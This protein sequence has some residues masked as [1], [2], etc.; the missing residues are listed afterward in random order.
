MATVSKLLAVVMPAIV[1]LF[2]ARPATVVS[3]PTD[4]LQPRFNQVIAQVH[5]AELAGA[6]SDEVAK[7]VVLLNQAVQLN[8]E[9]LKLTRPEVAQRRAQL[10][11]QVDDILNDVQTRANQVE[12]VASQR[13]FT[14][15]VIAYASAG[16]AAF[17]ATL[18][19]AYGIS[20]WH[21]YR[22]KRTFQMKVIPK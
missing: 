1:L 16:I 8:E 13:T 21:K 22:I 19:Y 17:L 4:E 2:L 12:A 20:F 10:L 7:L 9:A 3:Q 6:T 11:T 18:A 5:R 15:K 14:N